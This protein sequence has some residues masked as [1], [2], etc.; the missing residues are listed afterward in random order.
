MQFLLRIPGWLLWGLSFVLM[1]SVGGLF[2]VGLALAI[3]MEKC[4]SYETMMMWVYGF[5]IIAV[6]TMFIT[7]VD[8][9]I[10]R[11]VKKWRD[12]GLRYAKYAKDDDLDNHAVKAARC[13]LKA[14]IFNDYASTINL[15][16]CYAEGF[17][18]KKDVAKAASCYKR[19]PCFFGQVAL[20]FCYAEGLGVDKDMVKAEDYYK[21][22]NELFLSVLRET[23]TLIHLNNLIIN[24]LSGRFV[25][26]F[27]NQTGVIRWMNAAAEF[28]H[29]AIQNELGHCYKNGYGVTKDDVEADRWFRKAAENGSV[30]AQY[31]LGCK[32]EYENAYEAIKWFCKVAEQGYAAVTKRLVELVDRTGIKIDESDI[33]R[34]L[35]T[36]VE[37]GDADAKFLLGDCYA[38]GRGVE[39]DEAIAVKWYRRAVK[40]GAYIAQT[41]LKAVEQEDAQAQYELGVC[42]AC[43]LEA[44]KN[45]AE[46]AKWYR[47]AAEQGYAEAQNSLGVCYSCGSGV[48]KDEVEAVKWYRRAAEQG[49]VDAQFNLGV[50]YRYGWGVAKDESEAMK[51]YRK[52]AEQGHYAAQLY[53]KAVE[54]GDLDVQNV[55]SGTH[56]DREAIGKYDAEAARWYRKAAEQGDAKAQCCLG[57]C[58]LWGDGVVQDEAEAEKWYRKAAEQGNADAHTAL[59]N[60]YRDGIGVA[61]DEDEAVKWLNKASAQGHAGARESLEK[62]DANSNQ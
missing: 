39:K 40:S 46:A 55:P 13:F 14:A 52:A 32:Y 24:D 28:G 4:R 36:A 7:I 34:W 9:I 19:A 61:K 57:R 44:R 18:V 29:S 49:H 10:P 51:W 8:F 6:L 1:L 58:C 22:A 35:R 25:N 48:E 62:I 31:Y 23:P 20:G 5:W 43:G 37:N 54:Q 16:L 42:Y 50:S 21:K 53:L 33:V 59:R 11:C 17:G 27:W 15:G 2:P 56:E 12:E 41:Y 30:E 47:K 45:E 3:G 38:F 60:C 26:D